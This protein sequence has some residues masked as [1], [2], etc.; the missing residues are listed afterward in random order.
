MLFPT[1][2]VSSWLWT[3]KP[4]TP[5]SEDTHLHSSL[6]RQP[7][8][9]LFSFCVPKFSQRTF[10]FFLPFHLSVALFY[11]SRCYVWFSHKSLSSWVKTTFGPTGKHQ[12]ICNKWIL[13][14]MIFSSSVS[15]HI[16][17]HLKFPSLDHFPS[18]F[19]CSSN[20]HLFSFLSFLCV[21]DHE[22]FPKSSWCC[23]TN[24]YAV[25]EHF[26]LHTPFRAPVTRCQLLFSSKGCGI[27]TGNS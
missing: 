25:W 14:Q 8:Q 24:E 11:F 5:C 22:K 23:H 9:L 21:K 1:G 17:T 20:H 2:R 6:T 3:S 7:G 18:I 27:L 26:L 16:F 13:L 15:C 19:L 10:F 12:V 4:I